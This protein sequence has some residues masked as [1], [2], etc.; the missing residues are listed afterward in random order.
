MKWFKLIK[1]IFSYFSR[2]GYSPE[3]PVMTEMIRIRCANP[4]CPAHE[5]PFK[6][7][8]QLYG[9]VDGANEGEEGAAPFI[10][11]CPECGTLNKIFLKVKRDDPSFFERQGF[12]KRPPSDQGPGFVDVAF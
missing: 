2:K 6:L 1:G 9:A 10:V 4:K 7:D 8:P 3:Q 12:K 11:K 5:E